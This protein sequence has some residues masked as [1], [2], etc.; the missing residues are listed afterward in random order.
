MMFTNL[1]SLFEQGTGIHYD[2]VPLF[3]QESDLDYERISPFEQ[4][5]DGVNRMK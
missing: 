1:L 2:R 3:E 4:R 5:V